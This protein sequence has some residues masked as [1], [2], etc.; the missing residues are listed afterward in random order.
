MIFLQMLI[1]VVI[2]QRKVDRTG[3]QPM[4]RCIVI[5]QSTLTPTDKIPP[6]LPDTKGFGFKGKYRE[7]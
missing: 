6:F 1:K 4:H 3:E 2:F 7:S 5:P